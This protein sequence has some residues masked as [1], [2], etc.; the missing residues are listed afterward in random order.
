MGKDGLDMTEVARSII[1]FVIKILSDLLS[2]SCQYHS[3]ESTLWLAQV[4]SSSAF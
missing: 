4:D 2:I 3:A 1:S